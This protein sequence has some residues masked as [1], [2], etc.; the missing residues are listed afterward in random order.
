MKRRIKL[1]SAA[2]LACLTGFAQQPANA[3]NQPQQAEAQKPADQVRPDPDNLQDDP[4]YKRLSPEAQGWVRNMTNRL[5]TAVAQGDLKGIEQVKLE[6]VR[7]QLIGKKICGGHIADEGT[8]VDAVALGSTR[9][10]VAFMV[11]WLDPDPGTIVHSTVF[12]QTHCVASDGDIL[13][14]RRILR[15][16]LNSLG[17]SKEGLV[18]Y[19]A[20]YANRPERSLAGI[21]HRGL[22]IENHFVYELDPGKA[23]A[24]DSLTLTDADRDFAWDD[25]QGRI[26]PKAGTVLPAQPASGLPTSQVQQPARGAQNPANPKA[27]FGI[28][29]SVQQQIG[30]L[31]GQTPSSPPYP[32]GATAQ[33]K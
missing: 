19:E 13:D 17:V 32:A 20:I 30:K 22:F 12:T 23:A 26:V 29:K 3:Q 21:E 33:P 2:M 9:K 11:R 1:L 18:A 25:E 31:T 5:D 4:A 15:V 16:L 14:G 8:F 27:R 10:E 24:I 6:S 7:R 28:P